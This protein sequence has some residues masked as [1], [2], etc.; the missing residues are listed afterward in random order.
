[1]IEANLERILSEAAVKE[2]TDGSR[3]ATQFQIDELGRLAQ[4]LDPNDPLRRH[5]Q[6]LIG[7]LEAASG[8]WAI[9]VVLGIRSG[10]I[11]IGTEIS[12]SA[13]EAALGRRAGG[14]RVRKGVPYL[15]GDDMGLANAEVMVPDEDGVIVPSIAEWG[16]RQPVSA[17]VGG[18]GDTFQ[19][20]ASG[21]KDPD[22]LASSISSVQAWRASLEVH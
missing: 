13:A 1:M 19:I 7:D 18:R 9:D 20:D 15:V 2:Q 6:G 16:A 10:E 17:G 5:L 8:T 3:A 12:L 22:Q 21:I 4:T 14:G 11:E